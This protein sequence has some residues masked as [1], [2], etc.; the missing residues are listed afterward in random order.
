MA[1]TNCASTRVSDATR[2]DLIIPAARRESFDSDLYEGTREQLY[3]SVPG[4]PHFVYPD[5]GNPAVTYAADG[6]VLA[7]GGPTDRGAHRSPDAVV[8]VRRISKHKFVVYV[9]LSE[10]ERKDREEQWVADKQGRDAVANAMREVGRCEASLMMLPKTAKA[11]SD[12]VS[13][14]A[15]NGMMAAIGGCKQDEGG[16]FTESGFAFAEDDLDEI[17]RLATKLYLTIRKARPQF[18]AH[19][20]GRLLA[21]ARYRAAKID[22]ALQGFLAA[23]V[24]AATSGSHGGRQTA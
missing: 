4:I 21:E 20:R 24:A 2:A 1:K 7:S 3:A 19:R 23:S 17:V 12:E 13:M 6:R 15:W 9:R 18:Y 16:P 8:T 11:Y 10:M 22:P 5:K 14:C